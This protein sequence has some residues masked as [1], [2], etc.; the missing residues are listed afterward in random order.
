MASNMIEVE[1]DGRIIRISSA[2]LHIA[3]KLGA[4]TAA[5]V[6][7]PVPKE[8]IKP[9]KVEPIKSVI[10]NPLPKME[11][12]NEVEAPAEM[13]ITKTRKAPVKSRARK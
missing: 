8:L 2:M 4:T 13:V 6:I 1:K 10:V 11:T 9:V 3:K 5:K 12:V 7:K